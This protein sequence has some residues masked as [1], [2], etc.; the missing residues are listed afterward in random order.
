MDEVSN[1]LW[2]LEDRLLDAASRVGER[3]RQAFEDEFG[4]GLPRW[5]R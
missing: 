4:R 1:A 5:T 3:R 2:Y